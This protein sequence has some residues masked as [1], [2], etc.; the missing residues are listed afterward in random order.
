MAVVL[1]GKG[2][3]VR[4]WA[5]RPEF[6]TRI[7][8]ARTNVEYLPGVVFPPTLRSTGDLA[9]ALSGAELVVVSVP[10][11]GLRA[12]ISAAAP[13]IPPRAVVIS[14]TK[15]IDPDTLQ[16][17]SEIIAAAW[18]QGRD[19]LVVLSGP[20]FSAEVG[21]GLPSATVVA[22]TSPEAALKAQEALMTPTFRVYTSHDP[23]GVELGGA[24]KNIYAIATG[25][26]DGMGLGLN[27]RAAVI[28]RG[29]AELTR[30]GRDLGAEP[31]TFAGL[32][33]LGD[34]ILTC[35]GDLSRNRRCG[36]ALGQGKTLDQFM[37]E[38][39][40]VVEG[41]ATTRAAMLLAQRRGVTMP[42]VEETHKVLFEGKPP[43]EAVASL[44][45]RLRAAET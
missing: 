40:G 1:A 23:L 21:R 22:S 2:L 37:S 25:L 3:P 11:K 45:N 19:R 9:A 20:N 42:I 43:A 18:P 7:D 4:L 24:L 33:G 16:R 29:I 36:L 5:R 38:N 27:A 26:S 34:L 13:L 10:A 31:A 39:H 30:L 41:V 17:M 12:V 8:A 32:S 35:T 44:M 15:G 28:T 14:T 6:A